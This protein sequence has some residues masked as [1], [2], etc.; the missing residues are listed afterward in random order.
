MPIASTFQRRIVDLTAGLGHVKRR[1]SHDYRRSDRR[2]GASVPGS[3]ADR[4]CDGMRSASTLTCS[5]TARRCARCVAKRPRSRP[6]TRS[7]LFP[8]WSGD[9]RL[10]N[11]FIQLTNREDARDRD[12]PSSSRRDHRP[13]PRGCSERVLWPAVWDRKP[14]HP[15]AAHGKRRA[16]S[17]ELSS[18]SAGSCSKSSTRWTRSD[19]TW[20]AFTTPTPIRQP[21]LRAPISPWPAIRMRTI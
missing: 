9:Q 5:S 18:G 17:A 6:V 16:Q 19:W 7:L 12:H 4:I 13:R 3:R 15:A 1:R 10:G 11:S 21:I 14:G 8:P 20:S 2:L